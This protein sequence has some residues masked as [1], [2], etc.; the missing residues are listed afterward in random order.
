MPNPL[1]HFIAGAPEPVGPFSHATEIDGWVFITGQMPTYPGR[2]EA[3]VPEGITAQTHLVMDNLR[4]VLEGMGLTLAQVMRVGAYL[5][6]FEEDYAI[7]NSL[8]R[9]YFEPARLPARTCIGVTALARG[10]R[11][12]IDLIAHRC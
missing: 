6:H 2:P 8:Y 12:E 10:A 4:R 3:P 1:F 5:T 9:E 7:F 11:V